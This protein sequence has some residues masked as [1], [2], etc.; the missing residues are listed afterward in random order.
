MKPGAAGPALPGIGVA[1]VDE[2]GVSVDPGETG[3]LTLTRPWP[4]MLR[5]LYDSD[6]RFVEEY[7]AQFSDPDANE[8]RYASGDTATVDED[9]YV[10][11]LGRVDDVI[12][13]GGATQHDGDRE[14]DHGRRRRGR[15]RSG[16][17]LE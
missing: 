11:I 1:V 12:N 4:G 8:W 9:G 14:R 6:D 15:I 10:T 16:R 3:Y 5:T 2:N 13:A 7:W 17:S